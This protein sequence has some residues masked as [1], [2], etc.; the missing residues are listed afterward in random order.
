M[1]LEVDSPQKLSEMK[2]PG[3]ITESYTRGLIPGSQQIR[4]SH[5]PQKPN[6]KTNSEKLERNFDQH[7]YTRKAKVTIVLG[8]IFAEANK[9]SK[10]TG[11]GARLSIMKQS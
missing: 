10:N 2:I 6:R 3:N 8:S 7:S 5:L 11:K 9:S 4:S 1:S